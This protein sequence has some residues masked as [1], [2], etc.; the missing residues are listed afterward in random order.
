MTI[1]VCQDAKRAALPELKNAAPAASPARWVVLVGVSVPVA[2]ISL[3]WWMRSQP[4]LVERLGGLGFGLLV[5]YVV[6][7][8]TPVVTLITTVGTIR[9]YKALKGRSQRHNRANVAVCALGCV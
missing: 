8:G 4:D 9:M 7:I 3:L 5:A 2:F 6:I 1:P